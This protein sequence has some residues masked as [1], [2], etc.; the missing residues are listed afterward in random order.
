[1]PKPTRAEDAIRAAAKRCSNWGRW[2]EDDAL[3]TL[4]HIDDEKRVAA[5]RLV[6][7]G[8]SFSLALP[9]GLDG[10][11]T[12]GFRS[13]P[14]HTMSRIQGDGPG[15]PH[16][17]G[18]ADDVLF[19]YL[20]SAT[21]W[22]GLGH[23]ADHGLV[24]NGRPAREV[25]TST[26]DIGTGIERVASDVVTRGVLLDVGRI[27]GGG[28]LPDGHAITERELEDTIRE[29]GE[30]AAVGRGDV[31]LLRT[32]QLSRARREGWGTY[33]GGPAPGLS[34]HTVDWLHRT[35]IAGIASDTWGVEVRPNEF[36]EAFQPLHQVMIP[37]LGLL[38]G[39]MFDL[40]GLA[41]ACRSDGRYDFMLVAAP[42]PVTG[43][44][45]APANPIAVR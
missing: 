40:E 41:A 15:R 43:A 21:H 44:V 12:G 33:A 29:H 31:V 20:Q 25:V 1:M 24:W 30:S 36:P 19:M 32:G 3:G 5:A 42:L 45:G 38:V 39:E 10:P 14:V 37:H 6:R 16:G 7:S 18:S 22:D 13:N 2:A 28:E 34:F 26:G 8:R 17:F 9:L 27:I 4:N 23:I 11:Q 35:E